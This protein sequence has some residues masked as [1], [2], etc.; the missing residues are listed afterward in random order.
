MKIDVTNTK[1]IDVK[2]LI[3]NLRKIYKIVHLKSMG[4]KT[5]RKTYVMF[6][7]KRK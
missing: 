3:L 2:R 4:T 7:K 1:V 6:Y 5:G